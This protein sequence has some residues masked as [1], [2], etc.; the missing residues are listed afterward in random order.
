MES[1][2]TPITIPEDQKGYQCEMILDSINPVGVRL[3]T[4]RL[5]YPLIV[6]AEMC[7]HRAFSRSVA[8]NRAI[9][10]EKIIAMVEQDPFI[11][12]H[13]GKNQKGMQAEE[14]LSPE[15]RDLAIGTWLV[16]R[17]RAVDQARYMSEHLGVHKKIANRLLNPFQWVTEIV[18]ATDWAN[19]FAL[20]CHPA[21]QPEIRQIAEMAR[22]VYETSEPKPLLVGRWH[23]PLI[24]KGDHY[25]GIDSHGLYIETLKKVSAARCARTSYRTHSGKIS[26]VEEDLALYERLVGSDPKHASPTEHQAM[27]LASQERIGNFRG[28]R[29]AR[30]FIP[31][32]TIED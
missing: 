24:R 9:P 22:D 7:R 19:F 29:Q 15:R 16:Y 2:N 30:Y 10:T 11:P 8:S 17:D 32:H 23:L 12:I 14:E 20:R 21:A 6:H 25:K 3:T 27:A 13:W 18:T 28:W 4:M 5:K 31:N 1:K 26:T